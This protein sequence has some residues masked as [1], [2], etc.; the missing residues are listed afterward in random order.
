MLFPK[1]QVASST[2]P[3]LHPA[4][5]LWRGLPWPSHLKFFL[6][7]IPRPG[8]HLPSPLARDQKRAPCKSHLCLHPHKPQSL[9][10]WPAQCLTWPRKVSHPSPSFSRPITLQDPEVLGIC[11][12]WCFRERLTAALSLHS[13]ERTWFEVNQGTGQECLEGLR[14]F[15]AWN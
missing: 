6:I 5:A 14:G 4:S 8:H 9:P 7:P 15:L 2:C 10:P 11:Q 12:S 3:S 13:I 1:D